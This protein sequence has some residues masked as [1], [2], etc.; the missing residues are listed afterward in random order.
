MEFLDQLMV[1]GVI[2]GGL[3][4]L[5]VAQ[6]WLSQMAKVKLREG[7]VCD[8][9][10]EWLKPRRAFHLV[11]AGEIGANP[12]QRIHEDARHLTELTTDLG[13]GLLQSSLLLGELYWRPLDPLSKC[14]LPCERA[15]IRC[16]RLHRLVRPFLCGRRLVAQLAC[17]PPTDPAQF[18]ALRPGGRSALRPRAP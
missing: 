3:L 14:D 12:D 16:S 2:A 18:R 1:F 4:V 7:V 9:F 6:A 11:N 13:V 8:L 15:Q 5:N 10:D 17:R